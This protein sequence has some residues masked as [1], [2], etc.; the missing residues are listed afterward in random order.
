MKKE[1]D[2]LLKTKSQIEKEL[3]EKSK[4]S[5]TDVGVLQAKLNEAEAKIKTLQ[6]KIDGLFENFPFFTTT[7]FNKKNLKLKKF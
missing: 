3:K 1:R 7:L 2:D 4:K 6:S 5:E